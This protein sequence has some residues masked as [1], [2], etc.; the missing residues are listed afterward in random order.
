MDSKLYSMMMVTVLAVFAFGFV[1]SETSDSDAQSFTFDWYVAE[2]VSES[3]PGTSITSGSL[4]DGVTGSQAGQI[5]HISG[6]PTVAGQFSITLDSG[7]TVS[8]NVS[9]H[10]SSMN[11]AV[12]QSVSASIP[13]TTIVSG[14][15]P[16]GVTSS[17]S[18]QILY[19][20]GSPTESGSFVIC[21]D[22]GYR[23]SITVGSSSSISYTSPSAVDA[24]TGSTVS[25]KPTVNV[26]GSTFSTTTV[27]GKSNASW[28]SLNSSSTLVG[29]APSVTAKTTYY[30]SIKA[31][32]PGG[33]TAV[34]TVSFNVYPVAKISDSVKT[35]YDLTQNTAMTSIS[36][37]GNVGMTWGKSGALPAG[38]TL[39]G[40][41]ISG[42]PTEFGTFS[43]TLK[44]YTLQDQGPFQTATKKLTFT[45]AEQTMTITSTA[46]DGI[47]YSGKNYTYAPTVNL[48]AGADWSLKS[49]YNWLILHDGVVTG[50][51]PNDISVGSVSYTITATSAGGQQKSQVNTINVEKVAAFTSVPTAACIVI[52]Q[53]TYADDGSFSF[54]SAVVSFFGSIFSFFDIETYDATSYTW[55]VGTA[56]DTVLGPTGASWSEDVN[57]PGVTLSLYSAG[58]QF[59]KA[60]GTPTAAGTYTVYAYDS[61]GS[62][63][64]TYVISVV[65]AD[66]DSGSEPSTPSTPSDPSTPSTPSTP[67]DPSTPSTPS[68]S[69]DDN[70]KVLTETGT[71]TFRFVWTGEDAKVVE[72]DFGDGTRASGFDVTHTYKENGTYKYT[73]T[74]INEHGQSSCT[75]TVV[76]DVPLLTHIW[77]SYMI[78]IVIAII[79]IIIVVLFIVFRSRKEKVVYVNDNVR[80]RSGANWN[81]SRKGSRK[82]SGGRR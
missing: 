53:Y 6:S 78:F 59:I 8:M 64:Q 12:G 49:D 58:N 3:V 25:Y 1:I 42:T 27:T 34:Q 28:L 54:A 24:L 2:S 81:R 35:S 71:R 82:S 38:V 74:G 69:S 13:G 21:T 75:G 33:Q 14:A 63:F 29:T 26:S 61:D 9:Y 22:G 41:T 65:A 72:W 19:F 30:Y 36:L 18:S 10:E 11:W 47:Y 66:S 17:V 80:A 79:L 73:C 50:T 77:N 56:V 55:T 23:V 68:T 76:V 44:G 4:P 62:V 70:S 51:I 5:F 7:N 39:S 46:P 60:V 67:S 43:I 52:P 20:T 45:V 40:S 16:S 48:S 31:T 15:L 32:T 37:S 57:I